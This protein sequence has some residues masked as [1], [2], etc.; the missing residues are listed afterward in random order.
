MKHLTTILCLFFLLNCNAQNTT[1]Q[2]DSLRQDSIVKAKAKQTEESIIDLKRRLKDLESEKKIYD[3]FF[4]KIEGIT[5]VFSKYLGYLSFFLTVITAFILIFQFI[6]TNRESK[7][8]KEMQAYVNSNIDKT[9]KFIET[10]GNLIEIKADSDSVIDKLKE[11]NAKEEK[12]LNSIRKIQIDLNSKAVRL[13]ESVFKAKYSSTFFNGADLGKFSSF[14]VEAR[15][16]LSQANYDDE[17]QQNFSGAIYFVMG[18]DQF[19]KNQPVDTEKYLQ[20]AKEKTAKFLDPNVE[21]EVLKEIYANS[22]LSDFQKYGGRFEW[23]KKLDNKCNFYLGLINYKQGRF[24]PLA[25]KYFSEAI[26]QSSDDID[27]TFYLF[28]A[29]YWNLTNQNLTAQNIIELVRKLEEKV[30]EIIENQKSANSEYIHKIKLHTKIGDFCRVNIHDTDFR[31]LHMIAL[32]NYKKGADLIE[33]HIFRKEENTE[34]FSKII[35]I[36]YFGFARTL[37]L[38]PEE[39]ESLGIESDELYA[40]AG[41]SADIAVG[42]IENKETQYILRYIQAY[43]LGKLEEYDDACESIDDA[44]DA[45]RTYYG[46]TEYHCYSPISNSMDAKSTINLEIQQYRR[47]LIESKSQNNNNRKPSK[48]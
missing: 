34:H 47:E 26:K 20:I 19:L 9:S 7:A 43:C 2:L 12:R 39:S 11:I 44:L 40:K 41:K 10:Y 23:H 21:E 37:E 48:T 42:S 8:M 24:D 30:N 18:L 4:D 27:S 45:F 38:Y 35:P 28:Q 29:K 22:N 33:N 16:H 13:I 5:A 46:H 25:I 3:T 36:N 6:F 15:A 31:E 32:Q 17:V 1:N 14:F